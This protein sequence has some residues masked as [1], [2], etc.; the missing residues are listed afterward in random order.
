MQVTALA[1]GGPVS[2]LGVATGE[3]VDAGD[4]AGLAEEAGLAPGT[5][6]EDGDGVAEPVPE[7]QATI[8]T[9]SETTAA[10]MALGSMRLRGLAG[11]RISCLRGRR[12]DGSAGGG[13]P[14]SGGD[15]AN[16]SAQNVAAVLVDV[17]GAAGHR[18]PRSSRSTTRT[19]FQAGGAG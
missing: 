7:L 17:V 2:G 16:Q 11:N 12:W 19:V 10:F 13:Q 9:V 3:G 14:S 4:A 6:R 5:A 8:K 1:T 18:A 15:A